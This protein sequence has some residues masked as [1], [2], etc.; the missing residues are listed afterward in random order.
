MSTWMLAICVVVIAISGV[1]G[2]LLSRRGWL[3]QWI[4]C[5]LNVI[6]SIIGGAALLLHYM[7]P[8]DRIRS[9]C[10]GAC[11][12]ADSRWRWMISASSS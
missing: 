6:G 9:T 4:A 1:P 7:R 2:L 5:G 12:L 8:G 3:G 10:N 11:R